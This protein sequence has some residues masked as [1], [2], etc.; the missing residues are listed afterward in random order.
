VKQVI[1]PG[2]VG[3]VPSDV[4]HSRT[5]SD[6]RPWPASRALLLRRVPP[7]ILGRSN[8]LLS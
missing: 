1:R 6:R 2:L 3:V 5:K 4:P 8:C 7:V